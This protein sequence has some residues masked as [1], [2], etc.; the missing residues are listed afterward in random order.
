MENGDCSL[1][2]PHGRPLK[3][4]GRLPSALRAPAPGIG[5]GS[6]LSIFIAQSARERWASR[7]RGEPATPSFASPGPPP[8]PTATLDV[9]KAPREL[10]QPYDNLDDTMKTLGDL[11]MATQH[12]EAPSSS[13]MGSAIRATRRA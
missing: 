8:Q 9:P 3:L 5:H 2:P 12:S 4:R 7:G 10:L 6:F 1:D 13:T 11:V